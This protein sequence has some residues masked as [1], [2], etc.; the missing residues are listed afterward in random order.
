MYP[1]ASLILPTALALDPYNRYDDSSGCAD[2]REL[3]EMI[4]AN[5]GTV[6]Q[7]EL[8]NLRDELTEEIRAHERRVKEL[9]EEVRTQ[10]HLLMRAFMHGSHEAK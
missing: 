10:L 8:D 2:P 3:L 6:K 1:S 9:E 4:R 7:A 5:D